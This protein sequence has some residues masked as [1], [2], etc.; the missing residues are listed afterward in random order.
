MIFDLCRGNAV[1]QKKGTVINAGVSDMQ[2][3]KKRDN[4]AKR[5]ATEENRRAERGRASA[6]GGYCTVVRPLSGRIRVFVYEEAGRL[7][8]GVCRRSFC[9]IALAITLNYLLNSSQVGGRNLF[10]I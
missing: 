7:L 3:D 4:P 10:V 8:R 5:V 1:A 6:G 9:S 2:A